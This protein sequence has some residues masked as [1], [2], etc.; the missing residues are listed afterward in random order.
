LEEDEGRSLDSFVPI[1][2]FK[3]MAEQKIN[4]EGVPINPIERISEFFEVEG[5]GGKRINSLSLS[6]Q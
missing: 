5:R 2:M 6:C 4:E 1:P 3:G